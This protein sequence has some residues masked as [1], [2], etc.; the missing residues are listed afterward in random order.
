MAAMTA[1]GQFSLDVGLVSFRAALST[2]RLLLQAHVLRGGA[3]VAAGDSGQQEGEPALGPSAL[4]AAVGD[5]KLTVL[6]RRLSLCFVEARR[7]T[8]RVAGVVVV[9]VRQV[10]RGDAAALDVR[11]LAVSVAVLLINVLAQLPPLPL[12]QHLRLHLMDGQGSQR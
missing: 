5:H 7:V 2:L 3:H 10:A 4:P 6:R 11:R 12:F 9:E 1:N 8:T